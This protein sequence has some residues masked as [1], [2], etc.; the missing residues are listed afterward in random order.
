MRPDPRPQLPGPSQP[1]RP[2]IGATLPLRVLGL[3]LLTLAIA[4]PGC[5]ALLYADALTP[6]PGRG[7]HAVPAVDAPWA[8][9]RG[10]P[11]R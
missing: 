7:T 5:Q 2:R 9:A 1:N 11:D 4:V 6:P 10:R 3:G 8:P